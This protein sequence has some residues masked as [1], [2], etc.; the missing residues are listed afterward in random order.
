MPR[1]CTLTVQH[2]RLTRVE[3]YRRLDSYP[4]HVRSLLLLLACEGTSL[5]CP[6]IRHPRVQRPTCLC[7][8]T[9]RPADGQSHV[10]VCRPGHASW[11]ACM[12]AWGHSTD[13]CV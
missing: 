13:S 7:L 9:Q 8:L 5:I 2:A 10:G 11:D 4:F 6:S 1:T 12:L 3:M